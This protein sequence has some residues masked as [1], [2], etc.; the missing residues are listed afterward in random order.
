MTRAILRYLVRIF[1]ALIALITLLLSPIAYIETMCL[2]DEVTS[3]FI[4]MLPTEYH[5]TEART[6]LTYPEWHIVNAYDDYAKV[7]Q[8]GDPH[9]YEYLKSISGFW[10]SLCTLSKKSALHGG[11]D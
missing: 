11:F 9:D 10:S 5:R 1:L 6:F 4:S 2:K 7:I 3:D 8:L